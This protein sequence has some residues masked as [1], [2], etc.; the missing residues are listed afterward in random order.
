MSE[1]EKKS[2]NKTFFGADIMRRNAA[3]IQLVQA[4]GKRRRHN[5][6]RPDIRNTGGSRDNAAVRTH[7]YSGACDGS[8]S[9]YYDRDRCRH[10][11]ELPSVKRLSVVAVGDNLIHKGIIDDAALGGGKYDF[12]P[13]YTDIARLVADADISFINQETPMCGEKYEYT[14][15]PR[16][17]SPQQLGRDLVTLGFDVICF[18]NNHM[19][20]RMKYKIG[21]VL[22]E[23]E[24]SVGSMTDMM[25]FTDTLDAL[26]LG[27]YRS[28]K[29]YE[30]IRVLEKD[31]V[32]IAFLG[33]TYA[34]N[35]YWKTKAPR[36]G[37][38][39]PIIEDATV[40]RQI[41]NAR[42]LA[43][44]VVVSMHWGTEDSHTV[45]DEQRRLAR[46]AADEG[47][48]VIIGT[49]PHVV[50]SVEWI[51]G[52]NGNKMLCYYS[53]GNSLSNQENIDNNIGYIACFDL[54]TDGDKKYVEAKPVVPTFNFHD[55]NKR[56][57]KI[58]QFDHVT[59]D[60][61]KNHFSNCSGDKKGKITSALIK[62]IVT[63]NVPVE[64]LPDYLK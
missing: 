26:V 48:D 2:E 53:L 47:A 12:L 52:K 9:R 44:F 13:K 50:Q 31:G 4:Y 54:V 23:T 45:N 39:L 43:D 56:N 21:G 6:R 34:T 64:F 28:E 46:L 18:A 63:D 25:N 24:E 27:L 59:D 33:Y 15:Y 58:W 40:R 37:V 29:D 17:N 42:K 20:D 51:E 30:N 32:K 22:Q 10:D 11:S 7:R 57:E 3:Y 5:D 8:R 55:K 19:A 35:V 62:K 36:A 60:I 14:G 1:T 61:L 16:F 38:Y 49:H 41:A